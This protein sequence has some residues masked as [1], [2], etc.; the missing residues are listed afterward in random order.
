MEQRERD[1]IDTAGLVFFMGGC[2][3]IAYGIGSAGPV[4][5]ILGAA[6]AIGGLLLSK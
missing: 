2:L 1:S 6:F 5:F 3:A 4:F